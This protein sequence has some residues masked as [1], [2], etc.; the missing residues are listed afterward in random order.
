[1]WVHPINQKRAELG[2]FHHLFNDLKEDEKKFF[3]YFRMSHNKF[4][5]LLDILEPDLSFQNSSFR[6]AISKEERL[7]VALRFFATGD[8]FRTIAFSYRLGETTVRKIVYGC[9]DAIWKNLGPLVIPS[10]SKE[11]WINSER[12]FNKMWNFPNCVAAIDG[13]HVVTD[14]PPNSGSLFFNYKKT[15][16]IVLLAF[17][18][19]HCKFIAIDVGAYGRN[20]D[21]G[22]FAN[23]AIGKKLLKNTLDLPQDKSLPG[24]NEIMPHVFVGDEAFPLQKHVMRP[25]PGNEILNN[26]DVKIYNYRLSRARRVSENAFGILTKRFRIYQRRLQIIPE[27]LDKVVL[28][29]CCLHNFLRNDTCHWTEAD[30]DNQSP[31]GLR[32]ISGIGGS[33]TTVAIEIRNK[34]KNYFNGTGS[35]SWQTAIVRKGKRKNLEM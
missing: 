29:T 15:F 11:T 35:V 16:S 17:V 13:K 28:A 21:G 27:H 31:Q 4:L 18:D 34:F 9:C 14:K 23:S 8:T 1:M 26:E 33:S 25:Y 5:E 12:V 2:E 19:A 10:P 20:S 7:A 22:I 30:E 3:Q 24:T 6:R 32:D